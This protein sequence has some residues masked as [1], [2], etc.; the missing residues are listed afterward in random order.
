M[1][2]NNIWA[3]KIKIKILKRKNMAKIMREIYFEVTP[4]LKKEINV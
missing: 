1:G 2:L 4:R 3:L